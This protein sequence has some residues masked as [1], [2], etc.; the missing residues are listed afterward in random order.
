MYVIRYAF[1]R[2]SLESLTYLS[3]ADAV[4]SSDR[5][6]SLVENQLTYLRLQA[7]AF[8]LAQSCNN[9]EVGLASMQQ[10]YEIF[11]IVQ[12][13]GRQLRDGFTY[14][15]NSVSAT[16]ATTTT[17]SNTETYPS[18][19]PPSYTS[20]YYANYSSSSQSGS[21]SNFY[22]QQEYSSSPFNYPSYFY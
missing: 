14:L 22:Q 18:V 13:I 8:I 6:S 10:L 12:P 4:L 1:N 11:L 19:P 17:A 9:L 20:S 7:R 2:L 16:C 3:V 15:A 21:S 5:D